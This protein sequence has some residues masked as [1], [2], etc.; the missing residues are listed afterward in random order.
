MRQNSDTRTAVA[1]ISTLMMVHVQS[2]PRLRQEQS[3]FVKSEFILRA[4]VNVAL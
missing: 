1:F 3:I 2:H 4:A